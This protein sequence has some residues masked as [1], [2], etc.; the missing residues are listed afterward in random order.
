MYLG[1]MISLGVAV[2]WTA[3]ALCFEY[4]GKRVG[5]LSLNVIR[6][7]SDALGNDRCALSAACEWGS[8]A[9]VRNIR[10][11][12]I[13]AGRLLPVQL[14]HLH[15][16][17][18]RATLHDLSTAFGSSDGVADLGRTVASTS[19]V[20]YVRYHCRHWS[21]HREQVRRRPS[22][23]AHFAPLERRLVW[24]RSWHGTGRRIGFQ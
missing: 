21:L 9:L 6:L 15:R 4:A 19:L 23:L 5:T 11:H 10:I 18:F 7:G 16:F 22:R 8:L 24:H 14:L 3:T 13:C 2:S 17:P 1:E 12:R 20:R